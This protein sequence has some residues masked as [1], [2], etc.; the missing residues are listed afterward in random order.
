MN[1]NIYHINNDIKINNIQAFSFDHKLTDTEVVELEDNF[2]LYKNI[3][4]IYFKENID[5]EVIEQIKGILENSSFINDEKIEKYILGEY[6][7]EY[8]NKL[9]DINYLNP[10][11]WKISYLRTDSIKEIYSITECRQIMEYFNIFFQENDIKNLSLLEKICLIYDKVKLL[12]YLSQDNT[13]SEIV[14]T[15]CT[16]SYGYNL[17]FQELL[18]RIGIKTYIESLTSNDGNRF[19]T[20]INI[21]DDKYNV[22][23]IYM[24]DPYSDSLPKLKYNKKH[25]RRVN[26]NYFCISF[27][28]LKN[29][30]YNENITGIFKYFLIPKESIFLDHINEI[31]LLDSKDVEKFNCIFS[32][33]YQTLYQKVQSSLN[34]DEKL[35]FK[36]IE[37]TLKKDSYLNIDNM[38][39][40]DF[41]KKNYELK[42]EEMY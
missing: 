16:N 18:N 4:Q 36:I 3:N 12:D 38:K 27:Q 39:M 32:S 11:T 10:N 42:K 29:T 24:F 25:I 17:I 41:I 2:K 19:I 37:N 20:V 23:G 31:R 15:E 9:L 30:I 40:I 13:L 21:D 34:I 35:L 28:Q 33:D 26:Y 14:K 22:H 5:I 7:I 8:L 6:S 1:K